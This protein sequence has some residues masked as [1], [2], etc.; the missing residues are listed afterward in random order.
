M[1]AMRRWTVLVSGAALLAAAVHVGAQP[2]SFTVP[3]RPG[4]TRPLT[5]PQPRIAPLP[6][7]RW[8][9][10]HRSLVAQFSPDG[11]ADNGF[12]TL[13]NVPAIVKGMMPL[14]VHLS[15][16]STLEPRHRELLILRSAWL[17]GS[18]SLW[19]THAARARSAGMTADEIRRVALGPDSGGWDPLEAT[20]LRVADQI[21]RNT[22]VT[23]AT[24]T[25]LTASYDVPRL[26]DAV[27][28]VG[29]FIFVSLLY[30]SFGVQP[31][32]GAADRL[33]TDIPY[34]LSVPDKEPP[35]TVA[36]LTGVEGTGFPFGRHPD[37]AQARGPRANYVNAV[38]PLSPRHREMLILRIGWNGQAEFEWSAHVGRTGRAR[39]HGLHPVRIAEGPEAPGWDPFE[40]ALLHAA[41]ELYRDATMSDSTWGALAARFDTT[42]LMSAV[43][44]TA[45]YRATAIAVN[46][47]G[48]QLLPGNEKFPQ[49]L[50]W[51]PD[52]P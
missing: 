22:A 32:G 23:D 3:D 34:Y 36:R 29:H 21:Y 26:I 37:L 24:W 7:A 43:F 1:R 45:S 27:E 11:R 13:L 2:L 17:C 30:N 16:E 51:T 38:S 28:T 31:E 49:L 41:D 14:T 18:P 52:G 9:D 46:A 33:P 4:G 47:Y 25:A 6:E 40:A 20:L 48:V 35:L 10:T 12:R 8:T 15:E 50:G 42:S 19:A 44:T 39:E 5:L